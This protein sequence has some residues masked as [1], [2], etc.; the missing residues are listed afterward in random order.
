[1]YREYGLNLDFDEMDEAIDW[2]RDRT[3]AFTP[4]DTVYSKGLKAFASE[5]YGT[6]RGPADTL[7]LNSSWEG[8]MFFDPA[9]GFARNA[10]DVLL[11][12][13]SNTENLDLLT[14]T[15]ANK[16]V[17]DED[18]VA[19]CVELYD[20]GGKYPSSVVSSANSF[21]GAL[22]APLLDNFIVS[23]LLKY[24]ESVLSLILRSH[25]TST[26]LTGGTQVCVKAGG[27]I[28]LS[29]GTLMTPAIL[30]NSGIGTSEGIQATE[31]EPLVVNNSIGK[32]MLDRALI[33][34]GLFMDDT[35]DF[36]NDQGW[37]IPRIVESIAIAVNGDS[38]TCARD[39]SLNPFGPSF[40]DE[41]ASCN[42]RTLESLGGARIAE[43]VI[44]ATRYF[45]PPS[46]R[47]HPLLTQFMDIIQDCELDRQPFGLPI[48]SQLICPYTRNVVSCLRKIR[49]VFYFQAQPISR[50]N[51]NLTKKDF[52]P[53][54]T[55]NNPF[56]Y[57]QGIGSN[58]MMDVEGEYI[59]T[60]AEKAAAIEGVKTILKGVEEGFFDDSCERNV[61]SSCP[62]SI[63]IGLIGVVTRIYESLALILAFSKNTQ[64]FYTQLSQSLDVVAAFQDVKD[65]STIV[66][67]WESMNKAIESSVGKWKPF[68]GEDFYD[69]VDILSKSIEGLM[70]T[71]PP[72][73]EHGMPTLML[74]NIF[75]LPHHLDHGSDGLAEASLKSVLED[76]I[77]DTQSSLMFEDPS[78]PDREEPVYLNLSDLPRSF[79]RRLSSVDADTD[80]IDI[81]ETPQSGR[82]LD[83]AIDTFFELYSP[84]SDSK[85]S[86]K[87]NL[88]ETTPDWLSYWDVGDSR[89]VEGM[90]HSSRIATFPPK[91][92]SMDDDAS[93]LR[94]AQTYKTSIWHW[95]GSVK[96]SD[97]ESDPVD[98]DD[99]SVRGVA[100]LHVVDASVLPMM[101]RMNPAITLI[102]LG[103]YAA[104]RISQVL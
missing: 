75:K 3:T 47:N 101:P 66:E 77:K 35:I 104:K 17:F 52:Y 70:L 39:A 81:V 97:R 99:F 22:T 50:F 65:Q 68:L 32:D 10:V 5:C 25:N 69:D 24:V 78:V 55:E 49:A 11:T 20:I 58:V 98:G 15:Y 82:L 45:V 44:Y 60:Y 74:T 54:Q 73:D 28:V 86:H 26:A 64:N 8:E 67:N 103:R 76:F 48:A 16:I 1:M 96:A 72:Q 88:I 23:N 38:D 42:L 93:L 94:F 83:R 7:Q 43:G 19:S 95:I 36:D 31:E 6:D 27:R 2:V 80:D 46:M 59:S 41:N 56:L 92:P 79:I 12:T 40:R 34:V 18:N 13:G 90:S 102:G 85:S 29:A 21:I 89:T 84:H 53:Q 100:N 57:G 4:Q 51:M 37:S 91:L 33:P 71:D 30:A 87:R 9:D 61:A 63:V 62:R 14:Q